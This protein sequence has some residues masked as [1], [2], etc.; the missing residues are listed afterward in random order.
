M[1]CG[2]LHGANAASSR[3]HSKFAAGSPLVKLKSAVVDLV[4]LGGESVRAVSGGVRSAVH[5]TVA[6]LVST[7]PNWSTAWTENVCGPSARPLRCRAEL[8]ADG[9]E[10]SSKQRNVEFAS[11][12]VNSMSGL[13][14]KS[15]A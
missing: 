12:E 5:W 1:A 15:T 10:P 11:L 6:G 13:A 4:W 7:L 2:L 3:L 8:Q 14:A 9:V